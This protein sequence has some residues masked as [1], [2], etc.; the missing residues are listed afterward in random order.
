MIAARSTVV[1]WS[2]QPDGRP[3][4][5][6]G[7]DGSGDGEGGIGGRDCS[8]C[9]EWWQLLHMVPC[10]YRAAFHVWQLGQKN[11]TRREMPGHARQRTVTRQH[12][13]REQS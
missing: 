11:Y 5:D 3:N 2:M 6:S 4:I 7:G 10:L 8:G 13:V 12:H 1:S 9:V